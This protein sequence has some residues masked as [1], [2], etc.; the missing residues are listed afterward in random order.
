[1]SSAQ[2]GDCDV[3]STYRSGF[4][5]AVSSHLHQNNGIVQKIV[6]LGGCEWCALRLTKPPAH[7]YGFGQHDLRQALASMFPQQHGALRTWDGFE[8][9]PLCLGALQRIDEHTKLLLEKI[10]D[11]TPIDASATPLE[12]LRESAPR[13]DYSIIVP[14]AI[15]IRHAAVMSML[16]GKEKVAL[17]VDTVKVLI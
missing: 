1:M 6:S 2:Y 4:K 16:D 11:Y 13:F 5:R 9:C 15:L 3:D 7:F 17:P 8:V 10:S 12:A 14:G